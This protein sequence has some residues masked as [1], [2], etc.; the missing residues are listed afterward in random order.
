MFESYYELN[1]NP[2]RLSADES[3]RFAHKN[4]LKAWSYLSYA[5]EQGEGFVMITGQPGCGKTTLIRDI[6]AQ[7]DQEKTLAINLVTNQLQ[8][9]ELL[10]KVALEYGLP[11]ESYNKATLLTH[12]QDF[13]E[14]EYQKGRRAIIVIDE[15]QNLT[16]NGLEELR[17]LSNLQSGSHPLFQIFLVG[18]DE[19]R[20]VVLSPQMEHVRQRLIAT[21]QIEP[22]SVSQTEGYIEHRLGIVGWHGDPE[23]ESTIFPLIHYITKG[24]PRKVNHVASRLL[25]YGA[26]EEKHKF[27]DEDIWIVAEELFGEER[28]ALKSGESFDEFKAAYS[29]EYEAHISDLEGSDSESAIDQSAEEEGSQVE[30]DEEI[31]LSL[32]ND[33][34]EPD[35]DQP[36]LVEEDAGL[37]TEQQGE[38]EESAGY[39]E[40]DTDQLAAKSEIYIDSDEVKTLTEKI[41]DENRLVADGLAIEA[42]SDVTLPESDLDDTV[43]RTKSDDESTEAIALNPEEILNTPTMKAERYRHEIEASGGFIVTDDNTDKEEV[44]S[45][46][47]LKSIRHVA[48]IVLIGIPLI[49]YVVWTPEQINGFFS[50]ANNTIQTFLTPKSQPYKNRPQPKVEESIATA[51]G[52]RTDSAGQSQSDESSGTAGDTPDATDA[53]VDSVPETGDIATSETK[54]AGEDYI[55]TQTRYQQIEVPDNQP[56]PIPSSVSER[57]FQIFFEDN[58]AE[59]PTEFE[60]MLNDL[61]IVLSLNSQANLKI[62]G[63]TYP[64]DD[65]LQNMRLSLERAQKVSL[66]FIDRGIDQARIKIEGHTPTLQQANRDKDLLEKHLSSRRVELLLQEGLY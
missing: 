35:L 2:F 16:L 13:V 34:F 36:M 57:K 22:M 56:P 51:A 29:V 31:S 28:L 49:A 17:L 5:L 14:K 65:P 26:L 46:G 9:E 38:T 64:S 59:I 43:R 23:L 44:L 7:L 6:L 37:S 3:F 19:L 1:D 66:Y 21:C 11:A 50:E 39:K 52:N 63:Y 30:S 41:V 61:Y 20:G 33:S 53:V 45:G 42:Q 24:I 47:I 10:R 18:Q 60:E 58:N 12:I 4:Y 8:A 32:V 62:R 27:T 48:L 40:E 25:L 54:E 55:A 15:A